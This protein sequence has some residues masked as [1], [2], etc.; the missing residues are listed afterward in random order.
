MTVRK[1]TEEELQAFGSVRARL[2]SGQGSSS[3]A[4][5]AEAAFRIMPVASEGLGTWAVDKS[6]RL[7][8]DPNNL[9][10]GSAGW[11]VEQCA[12]VFEHELNHLLRAHSE[13]MELH[14]GKSENHQ[15]SNLACDLEINSYFDPS[16]FVATLGCTPT[17]MGHPDNLSCEQYYDL[18]LENQSPDKGDSGD[19]NGDDSGESGNSGGMNGQ[20]CGSGAGGKPVEGELDADDDSVAPGVSAGEAKIAA[21]AVASAVQQH[22]RQ[23]GQGSVAGGLSEW[24]A[25]LLT[26]P[27]VPWQ[28]VLQSAI[29]TGVGV[30]KGRTDYS[31][32]RLSR[33]SA[34]VPNVALPG[35]F[36]PQPVVAVILDTSGSMGSDM[37]QEA[38][39]EIEGIRKQLSLGL[40]SLTL[41]QV[42]AEVGSVKPW[43]G[44]KN[45]ELT[46]RG[47]TDMR[48]GFD[49]LADLRSRNMIAVCLTDGLTPWPV[50][51]PRGV[52]K[53][54]IGIVGDEDGHLV[55]R[56]RTQVPWATVVKV[57]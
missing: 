49:A 4:Y 36:S 31:Y 1:L 33:R 48:I 17:K 35:T 29:R 6:W 15:V 50:F 18:L 56:T 42:D 28:R 21:A 14:A 7:Y 53:A 55:E 45:L 24:A 37:I 23:H 9:P 46:G 8:I 2:L 32:S 3:K 22:E 52:A 30:V 41:I 39:S 26:P 43:K 54:I 25:I 13:R 11:T 20:G 16:G 12:E 40:D 47:G 44:V 5:Y 10:G 34:T 57:G 38:L 51:K 19:G 27:T